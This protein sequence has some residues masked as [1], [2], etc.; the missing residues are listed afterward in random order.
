MNKIN[1]A[2]LPSDLT[3]KPG[4]IFMNYYS[5]NKKKKASAQ[6]PHERSLW[7]SEQNALGKAMQSGEYAK[8]KN[9]KNPSLG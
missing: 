7:L 3:W 8:G 4:M 5:D 9:Q 6:R 2:R 1:N